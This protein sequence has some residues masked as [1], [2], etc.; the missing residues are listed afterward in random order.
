MKIPP[1]ILP[2]SIYD[3]NER[4][5]RASRPPASPHHF[6]NPSLDQTD[7]ATAVKNIQKQEIPKEKTVLIPISFLG[8]IK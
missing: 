5:N 8:G 7:V 3:I 6:V 2:I 4:K 1:G